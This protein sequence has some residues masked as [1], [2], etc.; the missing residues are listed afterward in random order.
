MYAGVLMRRM[1]S[2]GLLKLAFFVYAARW[3][4][5][6]FIEDPGLAVAAQLLHGLSFAAFLTA[7]VTYLSERT[8]QGLSTTA[9]AVFNVVCFG[10][11]SMAGALLGGYLYD[12][13]GMA[14]LLR[15]LSLVTL[16]GLLL[17]WFAGRPG[18]MSY[19]THA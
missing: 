13:V 15:V 7:G 19:A 17:F 5:L 12:T 6:S 9:Q 8:P 1:G 2:A 10:L 11:A 4:L 16:A 14:D 3:L 18:R